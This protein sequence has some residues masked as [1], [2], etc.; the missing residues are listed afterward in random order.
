MRVL[1]LTHSLGTN[2]AAVCL[3]RLLLAL[4]AKGAQAD[5]VCDGDTSLAPTLQAHGVRLLQQTHTSQYDVA[6][7]NTLMDY[8]WVQALAP[9]LPVVLWVHEG[10]T[11]RDGLMATAA[12]WA[13]AFRLSARVVFVNP[14]QSGQVFHSMLQ[15]VERHRIVHVAPAVRIAPPDRGAPRLA[16][17]RR[18]IVSVGSVYPRKRPADL[19]AAVAR[20]GLAGVRCTFVGNL[21]HLARNGEAMQQT[22]AQH[23]DTFWLAGETSEASQ[24]VAH[25]READVY[26]SASADEAFPMTPIEAASM[27]LPLALSDLP[28][29]QGVWQHGVNALLAPVGAVDCIAWNLTALCQDAA[30]AGRLSHAAQQ[31]AER[32]THERFVAGMVDALTQAVQDPP[33]RPPRPLRA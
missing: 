5:V 29:Y 19:V 21:D 10:V 22:L 7:V 14:Q 23:P 8:R 2:G 15:G 28:C 4:R 3:C 18:H 13:Q 25:L 27:G 26:C 17:V 6:L 1:A 11:A 9:D 20:M 30:L 32:F 31:V 24:V 12:E 33:P 16:S